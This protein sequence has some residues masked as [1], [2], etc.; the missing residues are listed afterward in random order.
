MTDLN[1]E[2]AKYLKRNA[3]KEISKGYIKKDILFQ[4]LINTAPGTPVPVHS[5]DSGHRQEYWMVP[6]VSGSTA[7]GFA[8]Y[9]SGQKLVRVG[10][11]G[12]GGSTD[13][14]AAE[15]FVRPPS[16]QIEDIKNKYRDFVMAE[17]VFSYDKTPA[18]WSWR[19]EL[20]K[21][22]K[23]TVILYILPESWYEAAQS[24][25]KAGAAYEG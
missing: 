17:P 4:N 19:L 16:G 12:A 20:S 25:N 15:Y 8:V 3:V 22:G 2:T 18:K 14:I 24:C 11:F 1:M 23:E 9:D 7:Y 13:H 10:V 6:Y 5:P 21:G